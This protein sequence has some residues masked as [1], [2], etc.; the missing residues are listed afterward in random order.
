[1]H[2]SL[3]DILYGEKEGNDINDTR[4]TGPA[5]F[6]VEYSLCKLWASKGLVPSYVLGHS[7]ERCSSY[8]S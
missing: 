1:M 2:I 5:M 4:Y 3:L 6:S 7:V 8:C